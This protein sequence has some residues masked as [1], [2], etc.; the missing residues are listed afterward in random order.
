MVLAL[1]VKI[2]RGQTNKTQTIVFVKNQKDVNISGRS[3]HNTDR[4]L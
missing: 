3:V 2:K 4:P 1:D